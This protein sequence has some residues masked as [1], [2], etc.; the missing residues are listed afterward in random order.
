MRSSHA[1]GQ[2]EGLRQN[3]FVEL[4]LPTEDGTVVPSVVFIHAID[5][6]VDDDLPTTTARLLVSRYSY[7]HQFPA[8]KNLNGVD[9][10][11]LLLHYRQF[12][13]MG[14]PEDAEL[15]DVDSGSMIR[16][17]VTAEQVA[18]LVA[19]Q[20]CNPRQSVPDEPL[21]NETGQRFCRF[22]VQSGDDIRSASIGPLSDRLISDASTKPKFSNLL[23]PVVFDLTPDDLGMSEG[24]AQAGYTIHAGF[25]LDPRYHQS[26]MVGP[27]LPPSEETH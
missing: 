4:P 8:F 5:V 2:W 21:T 23:S 25:G 10:R 6:P 3:Q 16:D 17:G 24:F 14:Q 22:A 12:D 11:E 18:V 20:A 13:L 7:L 9:C 15:I 26:W 1:V 19:H 27:R